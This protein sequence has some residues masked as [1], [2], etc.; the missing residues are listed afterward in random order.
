MKGDES[1]M[2][3]ATSF[4]NRND[5]LE[6]FVD[7]KQILE[8]REQTIKWLQ[9][10]NYPALPVAPAQSAKEYHKV[11]QPKS[12]EGIWLHCPLT[13]DRQPIPLYTG[14]NPSY[15]DALGVPHLVN[16]RSYQKRLPSDQELD[17]WFANKS[18]GVGTLGGWNNT[19]WLDFDVKQFPSQQECDAAV[20]KIL[21]RP[22]LF[23]T[24]LERTHSGG[25]RIGV[26]VKHFPNFTNFS[27]TPGGTHVGE[28]L[29]E[30]RFTVLAP[31]VGPSGNPYQSLNRAIPVEVE[32]LSSIGV[33]STKAVRLEP[34]QGNTQEPVRSA[35]PGSIPL[36]MLGNETSREILQGANPKGDRSD[37]LT[38]AIN[39]WWG[40][41]YWARDNGVAVSGTPIELA[42]YAGQRLGIDSDRIDRIITSV[43]ADVTLTPAALCRGGEESCWKK[44]RRL[45]RATF[46]AKCPAHIKDSVLRD[47]GN[48]LRSGGKGSGG[49]GGNRRSGGAGSSGSSD[50]GDGGENGKLPLTEITM[51]SSITE[52]LSRDLEASAETE[53]F[54][55]LAL[56]TGWQLKD[57]REV[58]TFLET[59]W[60]KEDSRLSRQE[61]IEQL[62]KYKERT[63]TLE[64]YLPACYAEPMTLIAKWMGTPT[65]AFLTVLLSAFASCNHPGTRIVVKRSIGFIEPLIIYS[66]IVTESGQRKSPVMNAVLDALKELQAE[67]EDR[68]KRETNEYERE[69]EQWQESKPTTSGEIDSWLDNKPTPPRLIQEFYLDKATVEAI[70]AI[71]GR[72]PDC[73]FMLIKDELSGLFASYGAYK[74][75]RGEDKQS[76]L[77]GWNGRGT[78]KN[79]KGGERVSTLRDAMSIFGAIQD[80]C[81]Q[82]QMGNF[83]DDLGE[84]ARFLWVLMPLKALR[85][86]PDDTSFQLGFLKDLYARARQLSPQEYKFAFDAQALYDN[87]HW[88]LEQRRVSNPRRGMRAAISK[89]EGYTA[90]LAL[91]LHLIWELAA[92]KT[93]PSQFIPRERVQA[94]IALS[95]FYLSQ[96]VLIHAE[97]AA[98]LGEGGLSHRL[99]AILSKLKQF[100]E[101]KSRTI[102][103]AISWLRKEAPGKL[104][105]DL[106]ELASLGYGK[107]VGKGNRLKLVYTPTAVD[108]AE[109]TVD[110]SADS[111]EEAQLIDIS[112]IQELT[113]DSADT[114]DTPPQVFRPEIENESYRVDEIL[115]PG[116]F[117]YSDSEVLLHTR[118]ENPKHCA[119]QLLSSSP[120]NLEESS[121]VVADGL[122]TEV[123]T[124][125][126]DPEPD[127]DPDPPGGGTPVLLPEPPTIKELIAM[128]LAC[129]SLTKYKAIVRQHKELAV[130]AYRAMSVEQ[131]LLVD[132]LTANQ[133]NSPLYK[134]VGEWR[135]RNGQTL[136]PGDLVR[137]ISGKSRLSVGVLPLDCPL[138][139]EQQR[140][141]DINPKHLVEVHRR[142][143]PPPGEQLSLT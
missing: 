37:S 50:G 30:G 28:A 104:R 49:S 69:L 95:E 133:Y 62:E 117:E 138:G 19:V 121:V 91:A 55:E 120:E 101:L 43:H 73:S 53:A 48:E 10:H 58:A 125:E 52:I 47:F 34:R 139:E 122:S 124:V 32:S 110:S 65:A 51:R 36:E 107:L 81:L 29:F 99:S 113:V 74:N 18:N 63:L 135:V 83:D 3:N 24:T 98:A 22:E 7:H 64:R 2:R 67:E 93:H 5:S 132:G 78:K 116:D 102:Q 72:Q 87:Y 23:G 85:L 77:S 41:Y 17:A 123:S 44:I 141:I 128:L 1:T 131:Q 16:H 13:A 60:D 46:D 127:D 66:G 109:S 130:D 11:V 71:K 25:W 6:K 33:Y 8:E 115:E 80:S 112:T 9:A 126:D 70:D 90:R 118:L 45:D 134:Y 103:S 137:L 14:K 68:F 42:H 61:E 31:T 92:G 76:I 38:T 143:A 108:S 57:I 114:V 35:I 88:K 97:G 136:Q 119:D 21:E 140:V 12:E 59:E 89:M 39:E 79:L 94:A 100:G 142:E 75:G 26:R 4:T 84:W 111:L 40:W 20:L 54:K 15:L 82:K 105:Q 96:V 27:L 129:E 56:S 106:I 86:P